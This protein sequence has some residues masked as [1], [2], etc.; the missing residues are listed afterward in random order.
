LTIDPRI[1]RIGAAFFDD[2]V[3]AEWTIKNVRRD[4]PDVRVHKRL[5]PTVIRM[6]DRYHPTTLLIPDIGPGGVRRSANVRAVIE[7]VAREACDRGIAVVAVS[8]KQVK[9]TFEAARRGAGRSKHRVGEVIADWFPELGPQRP[10]AR[11]VSV[12]YM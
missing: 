10:K 11:R 1:R 5:I 6:L 9:D 12:A 8:E 2:A 7:V 3:L 4:S